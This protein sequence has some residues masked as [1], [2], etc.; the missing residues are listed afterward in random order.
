MAVDE[1][2]AALNEATKN[3]TRVTTE[4]QKFNES[5]GVE[6]A[7]IVG[8]DLKKISDPFVQSFANI[9]GVQTLGSIGGTLFNKAFAKL[10][11]KREMKHLQ[12]Q[13]GLD[14][15]EFER[16]R[17]QNDVLKAE[18]KAAAELKSASESILG[19]S[20]KLPENFKNVGN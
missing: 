10:K 8:K 13:L 19:F 9:P 11:E 18:E 14:K 7:K 20:V 1:R 12:D 15:M 3:L 5:T 2:A 4:L 6:I 17:K 16:F